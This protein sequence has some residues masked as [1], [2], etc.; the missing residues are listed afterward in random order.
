[1]PESFYLGMM[2]A[3][4]KDGKRDRVEL[5]EVTRH[6]GLR[7]IETT[8]LTWED[9]NFPASVWTIRALKNKLV[10]QLGRLPN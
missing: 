10:L 5:T 9:I 2:S 8:R 1:M 3:M 6:S 7:F 4:K